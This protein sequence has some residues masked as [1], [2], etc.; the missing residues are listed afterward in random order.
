LLK[1]VKSSQSTLVRSK[2]IIIATG[3]KD[4]KPDINNFEKFDGNGAWHCP[5]CDG[6]QTTN[7]KLAIIASGNDSISYAKEFLGWTKDITIFI[8]CGEH[9]RYQLTDK[10]KNQAKA[11]HIDIVE[12][13]SVTNIIGD[14]EGRPYR[15]ICRSKR[16]YDAEVIFYHLGYEIQNELARQIGCEL[17]NGYV[18][19]NSMQQTT[20]SNVFAVGDIDTDRHYVAFAVASGTM[21]AISIYE[22]ILKDAIRT[23]K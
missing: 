20:V 16:Y 8:Q 10:D 12:N 6:F 3:I 7:K 17:D 4:V 9:N 14:E 11:L 5:H 23:F 22:Q 13:D 1:T 15:L 21:A 2:Y 19:V 18:K